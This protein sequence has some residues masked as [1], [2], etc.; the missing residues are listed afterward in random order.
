MGAVARE[1]GVTITY[2]S[3]VERENRPPLTK[4]R[5]LQAA[6]F[7]GIDAEPLLGA[8]ARSRGAFE[9]DAR[10]DRQKALEVGASLM[11]GWPDLTD[12][13]LEQIATIVKDGGTKR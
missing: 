11:R 9:L 7:F 8:A 4:E 10:P 12:D 1:L 3:D 5:I 6:E 13:Q 2:I